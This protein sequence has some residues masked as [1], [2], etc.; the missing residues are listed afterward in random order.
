MC[1]TSHINN[2]F[3]QFNKVRKREKEDDV[4]MAARKYWTGLVKDR[5]GPVNTEQREITSP[6]TI[7]QVSRA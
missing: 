7:R 1:L 3:S 6:V 4:R 5:D 2:L